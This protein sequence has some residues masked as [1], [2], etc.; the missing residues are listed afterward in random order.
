M[1]LPGPLVPYVLVCDVVDG[2]DFVYRY[3]GRGHTEYHEVDYSYKPMSS[4]S[5]DWA[6][7]FLL[8][9]YRRVVETK[10]PL[11]FETHYDGMDRPL[12]SSRLPLSDDG[13]NVT[14]VFGV[15]ERRGVSEGLAKWIVENAEVEL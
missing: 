3:W 13:E 4:I 8:G 7:D 12:Y 5:P 11:V 6:R 9:Q 10:K 1:A 14:G 15:A 2:G